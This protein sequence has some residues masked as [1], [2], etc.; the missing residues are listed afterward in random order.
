MVR[1]RFFTRANRLMLFLI[2]FLL[3]GQTSNTT[4]VTVTVIKENTAMADA[5]K[6]LGWTII[7]TAI[8]YITWRELRDAF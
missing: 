4:T 1:T 5:V 2:L 7:I 3:L 6:F 8:I